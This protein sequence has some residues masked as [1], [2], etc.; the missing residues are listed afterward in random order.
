MRICFYTFHSQATAYVAN[1]LIATGKLAAV[2]VQRPMPLRE[3]GR[4]L[5]RRVRRYGPVKVADEVLFITYDRLV[6]RR[7]DQRLRRAYFPPEFFEPLRAGVVPVH[8][9]DSLNSAGGRAVL[10][11]LQPDLVLMESRELIDREVL[12]IPRLGFIGCHPGVLPAY[13]GVY[14]SFWAMGQGDPD[15]VGFSV[16]RADPGV[17]TGD[18]LAQLYS[19]PRFP[20]R[21]FRVESERLMVEGVAELLRVIERA[22]QGALAADPKPGSP[23]RLFTHPGLSDYWK[24]RRSE[25]GRR[26]IRHPAVSRP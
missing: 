6:L 8:E 16:Y 21:H 5:L 26:L 11:A 17:D 4:L 2:I 15:Q 18:V 22:E 14:A 20:L 9:V 19:R 12:A 13:R 7:A 24:A 1:R 10:R 3:K 23:G 25:Y